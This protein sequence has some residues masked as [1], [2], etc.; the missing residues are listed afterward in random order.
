MRLATGT[1]LDLELDQNAGLHVKF[2]LAR[3]AGMVLS[4][5]KGPRPVRKVHGTR[6]VPPITGK[7]EGATHELRKPEGATHELRT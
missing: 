1:A 3:R 4:T 6:K 2:S 5:E 7:P